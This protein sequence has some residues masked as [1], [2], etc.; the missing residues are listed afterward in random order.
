MESIDIFKELI[1]LW[2]RLEFYFLSLEANKI[3]KKSINLYFVIKE[4]W[5]T[6]SRVSELK[7]IVLIKCQNSK[8]SIKISF[9][10]GNE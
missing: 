9:Q 10:M 5:I 3:N 1:V 6:I 2:I 7:S 8:K 4:L